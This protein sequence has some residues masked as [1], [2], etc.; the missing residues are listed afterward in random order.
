MKKEIMDS[1]GFK[2]LLFMRFTKLGFS[3]NIFIFKS[4]FTLLLTGNT[5]HP[6]LHLTVAYGCVILLHH[7]HNNNNNNNNNKL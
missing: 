2:C 3:L 1:Y 4:S 7:H 5:M 6:V